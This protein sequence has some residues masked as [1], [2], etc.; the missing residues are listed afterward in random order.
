MLDYDESS[1][2]RELFSSDDSELSSP[3][4]CDLVLA[5]PKFPTLSGPSRAR[6]LLLMMP[7]AD[8]L[9]GTIIIDRA[10]VRRR[11]HRCQKA[12]PAASWTPRSQRRFTYQRSLAL[13]AQT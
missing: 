11:N 5:G 4:D 7:C 9:L 3:D 6:H 13:H 1:D 8:G 2:D 12:V 10:A